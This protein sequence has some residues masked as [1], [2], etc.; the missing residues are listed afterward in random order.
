[1]IYVYG[2]PNRV[3]RNNIDRITTAQEPDP[4]ATPYKDT[5][6]MEYNYDTVNGLGADECYLISGDSGGPSF[7]DAGGQLALVGIHYYN[8]G[9][10]APEGLDPSPATRS[11][12]SI[13][14]N[15]MQTWGARASTSL[16]EPGTLLLLSIFVAA[17]VPFG[18]FAPW[19]EIGV[20]LS[21]V[22]TSPRAVGPRLSHL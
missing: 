15:S 18:W 19:Q 2:M 6:S 21:I 5:V 9:T 10:P 7:V 4:P 14:A 22:G 17:V 11:Y 13:S 16:P 3:G 12:P 20:I 8:S 1:M